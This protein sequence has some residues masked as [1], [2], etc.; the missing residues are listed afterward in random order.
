M[1]A[2]GTGPNKMVSAVVRL[3]ATVCDS[4]GIMAR[5]AGRNELP[6]STARHEFGYV[7]D[8]LTRAFSRYCITQPALAP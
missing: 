8:L 7:G 5:A 4:L 2:S 6:E 3:V 1:I